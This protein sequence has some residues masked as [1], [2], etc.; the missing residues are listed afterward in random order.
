MTIESQLRRLYDGMIH[1]LKR[2]IGEDVESIDKF[3]TDS[4]VT[5]EDRPKTLEEIGESFRKHEDLNSKRREI[6]PLYQRL[7]GKNRLLRSV[8]GMGQ[9]QMSNLQIKLNQFE[10]KMN[11]HVEQINEQKD[12]LK[13]NV[14]TR[15]EQFVSQS[16]KVKLRWQ[17]F[18]PRD[19][20]MED[21]V[22]CRNSLKMVREKETELEELIKQREI[23]M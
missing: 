1:H 21:E 7:E 22:K 15:Y 5:L 14:Q 23:I 3:A 11:S 6:L 4:L 13:R 18:R 2:S 10:A 19:E 17:Q 20:D 12:Q 16:E 9:E 8:T